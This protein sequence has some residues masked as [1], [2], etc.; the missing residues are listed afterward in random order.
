VGCFFLEGNS[1]SNWLADA[2][3]AAFAKVGRGQKSTTATDHNP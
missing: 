1:S 3:L 2:M